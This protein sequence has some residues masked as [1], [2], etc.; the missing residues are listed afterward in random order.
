[1]TSRTRD[2][3]DS[4]PHRPPFRFVT[5]VLE[6]GEGGRAKGTWHVTGTEDFFAGHFPGGPIVPGVLIGEAL[7]QLSGLIVVDRF[8]RAGVKPPDTGNKGTPS[9]G[10]LAHIDIRFND[11]VVPPADILME[12]KLERMLGSL[13]QFDVA[14]FVGDRQV[15]R[16]ALTLAIPNSDVVRSESG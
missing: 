5:D 15:A 8:C 2:I 14:A 10:K 16:G 13:W 9:Q 6:L 1:M 7:A 3:L 4:L 11:T 12:S